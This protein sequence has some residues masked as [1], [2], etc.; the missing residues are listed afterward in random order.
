MS[1]EGTTTSITVTA[2]LSRLEA[3]SP[4]LSFTLERERIASLPLNRRDFL[5]LSF[6]LP[7]VLPPTQDSELSTG[8]SFAIHAS[9]AREEFNNFTLDGVDNNDPYINR[10]VLQPSVDSIEEFKVLTNNYSAEYG[11]SAGAQLNVVTRDGTNTLHGSAYEFLRNRKLDAR[12]FFEGAEDVKYIRNQFGGSIGGPIRKDRAF[13][14][15][16]YET[17]RERRGLARLFVVPGAAERAGD[18]RD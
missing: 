1:P 4:A 11:R 15:A 5:Q 3:A 14:F 7:G 18:Y 9:G 13:F 17:L 6:L 12:N 16:N 10:Y 8:G 2:P